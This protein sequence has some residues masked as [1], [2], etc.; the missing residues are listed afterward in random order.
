MANGTWKIT[1][2]THMPL[3][4]S[5]QP[6]AIDRSLH[7]AAPADQ[8]HQEEHDGDHQQHVDEVA[9]RVATHDSEQPQYDQNDRNC[10]QHSALQ[11]S[12][13]ALLGPECNSNAVI[14][15]LQQPSLLLFL[16]A[17]R[18]GHR[19]VDHRLA[20]HA[21]DAFEQSHAAAQANDVGLDHDDVAGID[22]A[23]I[24]DALDA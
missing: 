4:I 9:Q 5:H 12:F 14:E 17:E 18:K 23:A 22:R 8:P 21:R 7:D 13:A 11:S 24:P 19:A 16:V 6:S 15:A 20:V 3:A 1:A 10:F 2:I